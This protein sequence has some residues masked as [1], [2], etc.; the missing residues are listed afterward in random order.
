[1]H[2]QT[3]KKGI[4]YQRP[5]R[6]IAQVEI[7]GE[8]RTCH[9]KNTG[10]CKELLLPGATVYCE[11]HPEAERKTHYDMIA[12]EKELSRSAKPLLINMDSQAPNKV[13][14]EWLETGALFPDLKYLKPECKYGDSRF[15]FYGETT[16]QKFFLEVKGVTLEQDGVVLFPDAPTERGVKHVLELMQCQ[17][18][19]YAAYVLFVVQMEQAQYFRPNDVTHPAFGA[20][21]RKAKAQGVQLLAY[22]CR[23]TPASLTIAHPLPL[24][25]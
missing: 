18:E 6:F 22:T 11:Y 5:N 7:E 12:V 20:A 13:V 4:F 10:R 9:V 17:Q 19:G 25:L 21:L 24:K 8:L 15:D 14:R 1:M 3:V 16:R 23:V 2:Y